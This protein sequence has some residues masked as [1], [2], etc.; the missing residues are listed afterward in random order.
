MLSL[1]EVRRIWRKP[2]V[3]VTSGLLLFI[4]LLALGL[5]LYRLEIQS[6]WY[7]EGFSVYLARMGW[8]EMA[9]RTA[10][11]IQPPLYYFFLKLWMAIL[12]DGEGALRG[13]SLVFGVLTVPLIYALARLLFPDRQ[14]LAQVAGLLA[15]LLLAIS[16]LHVW[17][18]QEVRMYTLLTFLCLLSCVALLLA[19]RAQT[20]GQLVGYWAAYTVIS[21][22]ALYTHYFAFFIL[23]FQ[24][25]YL[26]LVWVAGRFRPI[27][28][29][30]G[31]LVSGAVIL[32]AYLPWLPHL[33]TRY[34]ADVSYWPGQ[35]KL[36]EV[37]VD[38]A[39]FVVGGES[40]SEEVGLKLALGFSLILILCFMAI[41][42]RP[43]SVRSAAGT[44]SGS[45]GERYVYSFQEEL[46]SQK[47][48]PALFL[49]L[50]L[51]LP[52]AL[53]LILAYNAPKFNAR[54]VMVSHPALLLIFAGGLAA[55][56]ERRGPLLRQLLRWVL[57]AVALL[58]LLSASVYA[59]HQ[60][61][62]VPDYNRADFRGVVRHLREHL[63]LDEAV[64]LVSGHMFPVFDYYGPDL[65][66]YLLPDSPTLDTTQTLD[67]GVA[68]D[69]N[70]WLPGRAGVWI[71]LWQD[72]VVDPVG[73]LTVMLDEAAEE[74]PVEAT[75]SQVDLRHYRLPAD[76]RFAERPE[77]DH[78]ADYN[79]GNR[80]RLLGY[81]QTGESQVTLFWQALQP[82]ERDYRVSVILRDT[83]GQNW[84]QWDGR[85]STYEY[86]TMRWRQGQ[87][88][89]GR[90]DLVPLPGTPP[91]D[92]GLDLG[93]YAEVGEMGV[94]TLSVLDAA[95]APQG[96]RIMLGAVRLSVPP[97]T[98]SDVDV[99]DPIG[100]DVGGGLSLLDWE[101]GRYEAQPGERIQV[102][103]TWEVVAHP[104]GNYD[105]GLLLDDAAGQTLVAGRFPPT[106]EWHPTSVWLPGQVWRGLSTIRLP[107]QAQPGEARLSLQL[108]SQDGVTLGPIVDLT[109]I[110]VLTTTRS[111][112]TPQPQVARAANFDDRIAL[113]G[114]DLTPDPI[115]L[116]GTLQITLHLQALSDMDIPYT[117]FVH[118]LGPDGRVVA[119]HDGQPMGG[120]RPTTSWVPGEYIADAH[121]V[122]IPGNLDPGE[123][124]VEVGLYDA[125]LSELPRLPILSDDG[126]IAADR[127]IF[128][129]VSVR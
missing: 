50:Y 116:G 1:D 82:L 20:K 11:D 45:S 9:A 52:P 69:L 39:V 96:E 31:S 115:P 101:L 35:L 28:L 111:F 128:G 127:V 106:N 86:P 53:I 89:P 47:P 12:G 34:G 32:V 62:T 15:A 91:G 102:E 7:D 48:R 4:A 65:E 8:G 121:Q 87:V 68:D 22:A 97:A 90:Y 117:V 66:R 57:A 16:P 46:A 29:L 81:S 17:Y 120:L 112:V 107:I 54:Y 18:S 59:L 37:F 60:A 72:Q 27:E 99:E 109:A 51:L 49:F 79:F 75:F 42:L 74:L 13:L 3:Q 77:I 98:L 10:A 36:G 19:M 92:Y 14:H 38:I 118:L 6:L 95:G 124:V 23:A 73:Y 41:L 88:V 105:V 110:E 67:Y 58:T 93:L 44:P 55:L 100:T 63:A 76:L 30:V 61:Y 70:R 83:L 126:Q 5:R 119:G 25:I 64:I 2:S 33:L 85:P 26:L 24:A 84:G 104:Q 113:L 43:T 78:P 129:P 94:D 80:L 71:V 103:L 21:I 56:L 122:P 108:V 40:I 125:G 114:A 123:Y